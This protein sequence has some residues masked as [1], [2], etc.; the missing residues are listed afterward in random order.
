MLP[1][2]TTAQAEKSSEK[3]YVRVLE[4]VQWNRGSTSRTWVSVLG[5][6]SWIWSSRSYPTRK[7]ARAGFRRQARSSVLWQRFV[8]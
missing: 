1:V 8:Y 3:A 2:L 7:P 5:P 4:A 6:P